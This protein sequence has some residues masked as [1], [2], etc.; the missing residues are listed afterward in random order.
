MQQISDCDISVQIYLKDNKT[1]KKKKSLT[2]YLNALRG[3]S[4]GCALRFLHLKPPF[5]Q[6][7]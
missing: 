6:N 7:H 4:M 3:S 1:L 2:L 5:L